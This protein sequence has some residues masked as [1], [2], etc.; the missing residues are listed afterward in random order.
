MTIENTQQ[1]DLVVEFLNRVW[2]AGELGTFDEDIVSDEYVFRHQ[3]D[4]EFPVDEWRGKWAEYHE[5]FEDVELQIE[6]VLSDENKVVARCRLAGTHTGEF[7][8]VE[9]TGKRIETIGIGIFTLREDTI[10]KAWYV[11]DVQR[12]FKQLHGGAART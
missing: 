5:A 9:P 1:E 3:T 12:F 4:R 6:E 8:G 7:Q 2:E 11:E 10:E